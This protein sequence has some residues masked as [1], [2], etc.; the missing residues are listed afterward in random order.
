VEAALARLAASLL[1]LLLGVLP[2]LAGDRAELNLLGYSHDLR[3]FAF[4]E[5]GTFDGSGGNYS[6]IYVVDLTS[7]SWV[8]GT[9][10]S[11]EQDGDPDQVAPDLPAVRAKT[12][13]LAAGMLGKLKVDVPA[14]TLVLLGDGVADADGK[15]MTT[16]FPSCCGPNDTDATAGLTLNLTT[17]A[18]KSA[19]ACPVDEAF[20]YALTA[21]FADGTSRELHRDGANLPKSRSCPQDYRLYGIFAPLEQFGPRVALVSSYP[22]AFEGTSRRFLAVPIDTP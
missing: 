13:S 5:F 12:M 15:T 8:D 10:F 22:F 4:E 21:T 9:P 20:G 6:H 16:A 14:T 17:F 19:V 18:A 3:Y 7:D 1:L 2:A 11:T